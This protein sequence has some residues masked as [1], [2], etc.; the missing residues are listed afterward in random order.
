MHQQHKKVHNG[1]H[2]SNHKNYAAIKQHITRRFHH[3]TTTYAQ[4]LTTQQYNLNQTQLEQQDKITKLDE[5]HTSLQ[6]AHKDHIRTKT[7][8]NTTTRTDHR[9]TQRATASQST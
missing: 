8:T 3:N 7:D 1:N 9:T 5:L 2:V 6:T 4:A